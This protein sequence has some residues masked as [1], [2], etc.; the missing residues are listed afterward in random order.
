[1]DTNTDSYT[2]S[3]TDY[4]TDVSLNNKRVDSPLNCPHLPSPSQYMLSVLSILS[5]L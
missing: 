3:N 1:M 4:N 5:F 2:D